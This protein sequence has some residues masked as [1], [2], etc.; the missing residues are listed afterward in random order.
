M[1]ILIIG[2]GGR[3]HAL[4][5]KF[6]EDTRVNQVHVFPGNA[7]MNIFDEKIFVYPNTSWPDFLKVI[8]TI[9]FEFALIGSES[10]ILSDKVNELKNLGLFVVAP[11]LD[12]A[13]LESSKI[14]CKQI[15]NKAMIKTAKSF[16]VFSKEAA[17]MIAR[18]EFKSLP[19]VIKLSGLHAGKG[20]FVAEKHELGL[21]QIE[22][23]EKYFKDGVLLEELLIGHEVS[24]FYLCSGNHFTYLGEACDYKRLNDLNLGPN[25]GGMGAF[26]PDPHLNDLERKQVE[27]EIIIPTLKTMSSQN[28]PFEGVLFAGLMKT[29]K[30]LYVIEYNVRFG[31][32]ET[33]CFLPR[34]QNGFL[35]AFLLFK[36]S[37][38]KLGDFKLKFL[39]EFSLFVVKAHPNYPSKTDQA[40]PVHI[41]KNDSAFIFAGIQKKGN[42]LFTDGG[43]VLGRVE[44]GKSLSIARENCY[45][46]LK[47]IEFENEKFRNDIGIIYGI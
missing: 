19:F 42:A 39:E 5:R 12:A 11:S 16:E 31:D 24:M 34:I 30:G 46:E 29:T 25:T 40:I 23:W 4:A 15:L 47:N 14:F 7:G 37:P 20:V 26:S 18:T 36:N 17:L 3:E 9:Q 33:Q 8:P 13:K 21:K 2:K 6:L 32:P 22:E 35:D 43:R 28:I 1:N 41:N 38:E 44:K 10:D 27:V 45:Q